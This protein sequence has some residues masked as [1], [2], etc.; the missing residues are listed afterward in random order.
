[1][2]SR[3]TFTAWR[4]SI[5]SKKLARTRSVSSGRADHDYGCRQSGILTIFF[6]EDEGNHCGRKSAVKKQ[7]LAVY[8]RGDDKIY[9]NIGRRKAAENPQQRAAERMAPLQ[10]F[11]IVKAIAQTYEHNRNRRLAEHRDRVQK[12]FGDS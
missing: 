8:A 2:L 6:G 5:H 3:V 12:K 4:F 9:G 10:R 7:N 11:H 1:M